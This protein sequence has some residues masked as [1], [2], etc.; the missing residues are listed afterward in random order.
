MKKT[1]ITALALTHG[2]LP[3]TANLAQPDPDCRLAHVPSAG[4]APP[5]PVA[6]KNSF[7]FGGIN[8]SLVLSRYDEAAA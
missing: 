2:W 1:A 3:A 4:M 6:V 5:L 8:A 7:G